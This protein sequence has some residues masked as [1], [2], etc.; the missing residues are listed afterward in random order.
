MASELTAM[1][2]MDFCMLK[3]FFWNKINQENP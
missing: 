1:G 3:L 2:V